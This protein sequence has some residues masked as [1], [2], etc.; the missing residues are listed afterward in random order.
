MTEIGVIDVTVVP[1]PPPFSV[2]SMANVYSLSGTMR[3]V[4]LLPD[5]DESWTRVIRDPP[6]A[7]AVFYFSGRDLACVFIRWRSR[8]A[9]SIWL[10][11]NV[12]NFDTLIPETSTLKTMVTETLALETLRQILWHWRVWHQK[13]WHWKLW[14]GT[15]N[16]DTGHFS[17]RNFGTGISGTRNFDTGNF[18][19]AAKT[20]TLENI[21]TRYLGTGNLG[22]ENLN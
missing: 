8:R 12:G 18:K 16:F 9:A 22:A 5:H 6:K 17:T 11:W 2:N 19:L 10:W 7:I 14:I 20:S 4:R 13:H 3:G 21:G 15:R 1:V